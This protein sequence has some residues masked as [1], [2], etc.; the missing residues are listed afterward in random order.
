MQGDD[1]LGLK[2]DGTIVAWGLNT[3]GQCDVGSPNDGYEAMSAGGYHSLGLQSPTQPASVEEGAVPQTASAGARLDV[4]TVAPNPI[5]TSAGISFDLRESGAVKVSVFDIAG[6]E[7]ATSA[8]GTFGPGRHQVRWEAR[9]A[10][11]RR[12]PSGMYFLRM[13]GVGGG[14]PAQRVIVIR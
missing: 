7:V 2:S 8:L 6:R 4:L 11:G 13:Q 3:S 9:D 10:V 14:S 12:L 5:A 1:N